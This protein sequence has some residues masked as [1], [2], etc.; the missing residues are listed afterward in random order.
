MPFHGLF[1]YGLFSK[2]SQGQDIDYPVIEDE[3]EEEE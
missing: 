2:T 3:E 1:F